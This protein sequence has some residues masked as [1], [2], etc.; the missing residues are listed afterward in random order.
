MTLRHVTDL[1]TSIGDVIG[2]AAGDGVLI[3]ADG[4]PTFALMPMDDDLLDYLLERNPKFIAECG[5]ISERM[6][7]GEFKTHEEVRRILG[8]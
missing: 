5:Q 3:D 8:V 2:A 6:R 1:K 7:Q 4:H